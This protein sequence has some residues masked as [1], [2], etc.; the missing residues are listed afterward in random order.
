MLEVASFSR[1]NKIVSLQHNE[2]RNIM[3]LPFTFLTAEKFSL[4]WEL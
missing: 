4:H 1:D 3:E 2:A